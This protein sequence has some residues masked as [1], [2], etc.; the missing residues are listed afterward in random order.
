M[1]RYG[2]RG[3]VD[4]YAHDDA[5]RVL[6]G[7][8]ATRAAQLDRAIEPILALFDGHH[9]RVS[10]RVRRAS[11]TLTKLET[12]WDGEYEPKASRISSQII[13]L[14]KNLNVR[15]GRCGLALYGTKKFACG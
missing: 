5:V 7:T 4:L 10:V 14:R 2:H 15:V 11:R 8:I 12:S 3:I 6:L 13:L 1:R 9:V